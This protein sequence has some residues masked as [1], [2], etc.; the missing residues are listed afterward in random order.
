[1]ISNRRKTLVWT[2]LALAMGILLVIPKL[3]GIRIQS[4]SADVA[5]DLFPAQ[6]SNYLKITQVE[7]ESGW[8]RSSA[9]FD[10]EY[11]NWSQIRSR[12]LIL[13]LDLQIHH[14][15][16]LFTRQGLKSG[17]AYVEIQPGLTGLSLTELGPELT[18]ETPELEFNL[19]ATLAG[20]V[21]V[22]IRMPE[23]LAHDQ[24]D[25]H[26]QVSGLQGNISLLRAG[27]SSANFSLQNASIAAEQD[28]V[29]LT[30][31]NLALNAESFNN[32]TAIS[33]GKF[34][35]SIAQISS[36]EP[37]P[38]SLDDIHLD[39]AIEFSD[40]SEQQMSLSQVFTMTANHSNIPLQYL[41]WNAE[42][43]NVNRDMLN[44][45]FDY[46]GNQQTG[47]LSAAGLAGSE[48][49]TLQLL[50]N[51]LEFS[52]QLTANAFDGDHQI[53]LTIKWLGLPTLASTAELDVGK[54]LAGLEISLLLDSDADAL[55]KSPAG[56][57]LDSF[58]QQDLLTVVNGRIVVKGKLINS[59][60]VIN[61]EI[62]PLDDYFAI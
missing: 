40:S 56:E 11:L 49:L 28:A 31:S 47:G 50:Q 29:D 62:V 52:N 55:L 9:K 36:Q 1:M 17:L 61:D 60:L 4:A 7:F 6:A 27:S 59:E 32:A 24:L 10:I 23:F 37:L 21:Q 13:L 26:L 25:T 19:H 5:M 45:Y 44:S 22:R 48:T 15:P 43:L 2:G 14:G 58:I 38:F 3:I 51:A 20:D 42:L 35:F 34:S 46:G 33:P 16:L 30:I 57:M 41:K 18:V 53:T 8:F 12:P 39:Y 54:L